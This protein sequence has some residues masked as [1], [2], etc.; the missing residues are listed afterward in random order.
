MYIIDHKIPKYL[1]KYRDEILKEYLYWL[2]CSFNKITQNKINLAKKSVNCFVLNSHNH[3]MANNKKMYLTLHEEHYSHP[4]IVNG[5]DTRRKVSYTY[6]KSLFNF[7]NLHNYGDLKIGGVEDYGFNEEGKWTAVSF[8]SSLFTLSDK[9]IKIYKN[10]VKQRDHFD[11]LENVV[12]LRKKGS[13]KEEKFKMTEKVVPVLDFV[14]RYNEFSRSKEVTLDGIK[15]DMQIY[16][17]FNGDFDNGG[18]NYHNSLYQLIS[19]ED[20]AK[21]EIEG[22]ETVC[23]DYGGFEPCI[24]YSMNQEVMEMEDPYY[25]DS[26]LELGYEFNT[27][28]KLAKLTLLICLNVDNMRSA[29]LAINKS[30]RDNM[31]TEKLFKEGMIPTRVINVT[32]LI[33]HVRSFHHVIGFMFFN[34]A[35]LMVQNIGSAINNY[36]LDHMMQVHGQLVIQT[37]DDFRVDKE[38]EEE[39]KSVMKEAFNVVLGFDDNCRIKKEE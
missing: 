19:G 22:K 25:V 7:L 29:K 8:T 17:I 18:R 31:D 2:E 10:T 14:R 15:L 6:T 39:L 32:E 23:Y 38:Y 37:H 20:R 16:K 33:D 13:N 1:Y 9:L 28:R 26:L 12:I 30:I 5:K 11:E 36:I 35:G 34:N 4:R 24:A 3:I 21:V 27:A